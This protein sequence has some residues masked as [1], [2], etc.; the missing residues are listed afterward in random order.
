MHIGTEFIE[1][2][3]FRFPEAFKKIYATHFSV[4]IEGHKKI[5]NLKKYLFID[6]AAERLIGTHP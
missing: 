1:G 2:G 3:T 6:T 5:V 4:N